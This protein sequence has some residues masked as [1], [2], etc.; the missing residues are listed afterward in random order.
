MLDGEDQLSDLDKDVVTPQVRKSKCKS[1]SKWLAL[2]AP[3]NK[4][5]GLTSII[6]PDGAASSSKDSYCCV[7]I[8]PQHLG[9]NRCLLM[10]P[11][12]C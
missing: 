6:G 10:V 1:L 9:T 3:K 2:W 4:R 12:K 8:G 11:L 5:Y 7:S